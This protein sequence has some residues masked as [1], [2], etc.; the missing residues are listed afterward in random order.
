MFRYDASL[1]QNDIALV[2]LG[3]PVEF[4]SSIRLAV[5]QT[6]STRLKSAANKTVCQ[7]TPKNKERLKTPDI[8]T[9]QFLSQTSLSSHTQRCRGQPCWTRG[10]TKLLKN[11]T[12]NKKG[13]Q[14]VCDK[15]KRKEK[16]INQFYVNNTQ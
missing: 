10:R 9:F 5:Y 4:S 11:Q 13:T 15:P 14:T 1:L 3:D 12:K 2:H 7:R 16:G 8:F 6:T